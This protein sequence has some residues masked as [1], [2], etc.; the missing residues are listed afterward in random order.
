MRNCDGDAGQ[1]RANLDNIVKHYMNIH[2]DCAPT[3]RCRTD[4][5][6]KSS[7]I[8]LTDTV[9]IKLLTDAIRSCDVYKNAENYV[10]HTDTFFNTL[11]IFQ[12][13]R[14]GTFGDIQYSMRSNLAVC[15]WNEKCH[16]V[17]GREEQK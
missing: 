16:N 14:V 9:A 5:N 15:D 2:T 11:N 3:S 8:M 6:N 1:L 17:F 12:D 7:R 4:S 13:K 10:H